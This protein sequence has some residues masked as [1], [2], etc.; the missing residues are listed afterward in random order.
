[1]R[2]MSWLQAQRNNS[3]ACLRRQVPQQIAQTS[4]FHMSRVFKGKHRRLKARVLTDQ[5]STTVMYTLSASSSPT[6]AMLSIF[7]DPGGPVSRW[8]FSSVRTL[9]QSLP[10]LVPPGVAPFCTVPSCPSP[11]SFTHLQCL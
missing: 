9:Y 5:V 4:L 1:M 6:L 10:F 7:L 8:H 2:S 11:S 3:G